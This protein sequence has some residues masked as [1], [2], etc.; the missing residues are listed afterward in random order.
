[1]KSVSIVIPNWNGLELLTEYFGSVV[2][3]AE[4]YRAQAKADVEVIVVDDASKDES[5]RWLR[6]NFA[7]HEF[8]KLV[9]LEENLGFLRAANRGFEAAKH[10]V[11]FLLNNDVRV[12]PDCIVPLVKHFDDDNVFAVCCR[13][14]RINGGRLDGGGKIGRFE[15]GFWRVFLNYEALSA[16]ETT[17]FISFFGSGGYTAYDREKLNLQGGFQDCLS[18]NYWEDVELCYRAWKRGWTVRYE[19]KSR[20]HHLGSESMKKLKSSEMD[21][22][23]ERNRL[24]MT[25]INL[26]D[27]SW[28]AQHLGWLTLKL[29]GSA[30]SLRWNYLRSFGRALAKTSKV[31]DARRIERRSALISDH[32]LAE[33]FTDLAKRPGIYV[34]ENERA[35][36][37][38]LEMETNATASEIER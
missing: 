8:V 12:E 11:V 13:A 22:V 24:L 19:P 18:P 29:A 10:D 32:D 15:R 3:A 14:D 25:W 9:E 33:R 4:E 21:I 7:G 35:E 23:T 2:A 37:A 28:F 1:M 30:I 5:V 16:Q 31:L 6:G 17:E 38:F 36:I 27:K 20:V 26:H 34:V